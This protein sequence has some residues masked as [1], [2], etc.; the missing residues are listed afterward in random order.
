MTR[1]EARE[2]LI[3]ILRDVN[4]DEQDMSV[5]PESFNSAMLIAI[6]ALQE[7]SLPSDVDEAAEQAMPASYSFLEVDIY[8]G[9]EPVYS[10]EQM[11]EMFKA[12][13]A[14]DRAKMLEEAVE[15]EIEEVSFN[16]GEKHNTVRFSFDEESLHVEN[17]IWFPRSGKDGD[18]VRIVILK[19][20]ED[21]SK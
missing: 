17:R 6:D 12:G 7:P 2:T 19:D 11:V 18:K 8:G 3:S 16:N 15:G 1:E 21:E 9:S 4:S 13:V 10:Y 14:Y 20:N 5:S